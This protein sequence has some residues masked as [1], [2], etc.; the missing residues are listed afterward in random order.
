MNL[1][2]SEKLRAVVI[3]SIVVLVFVFGAMMATIHNAVS[4]DR[5]LQ[6]VYINGV[7][8]SGLNRAEANQLLDEYTAA[9][10]LN[11]VKI[12]AGK[13][14][15]VMEVGD[16]NLVIKTEK[17]VQEAYEIGRGKNPIKNLS[18]IMRS[19]NKKKR[20][21]IAIETSISKEDA[22]KLIDENEK[23]LI[24]KTKN[25]SL[26]RKNGK[27]VI[28]DEVYGVAIKKEESVE[29]IQ[30]KVITDWDQ[31]KFK[32]KLKVEKDKPDYLAKDMEE[33][34][35]VIGS[36]TTQYGTSAPGRK[37][38][39]ARGA[40]LINGTLLLPGETFS[41]YEKISPMNAENG[42]ALAP[43]YASGQVVQTY[44]GGIC[45]VSTTLYN[46]VLRA[47]LKVVERSNHSMTV[48]YVPLAADAAISGTSKDFK[49]KNDTKTPIY[50]E[51]HADGSTLSFKLYGKETRDSN[52]RLEF[53][54]KTTSVKPPKTKE[55][56][57]KTLP[58]GKSV[59][60][61]QGTTGYNAELYKVV[62]VDDK[63][64]ERILINRSSYNSSPKIVRIGAMKK[65]KK[66]KKDVTA[67][68]KN[69][70]VI[71]TA[72]AKPGAATTAKKPAAKTT[73]K[74]KTTTAK[75]KATT[76]KKKA[77]AKKKR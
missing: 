2:K 54:S 19:K 47:E 10:E 4:D 68:D 46:A 25:A 33:V 66:D 75:K 61:S 73:A 26:K 39:V 63:E 11:S 29:E 62:Y 8:V 24:A 27:F 1:L 15:V 70:N 58:I 64:T 3:S 31:D 20:T 76:A 36:Y 48:H 49:F 45:Q 52:R 14:K 13:K 74:K 32:I 53:E 21:D 55:I 5:I 35:D 56:K 18:S 16:M 6:N 40:S 30:K 41:A 7:D 22:Q 17:A 9:K 42:Y 23:D 12:V 71:T 67:T 72:T 69:G 43:S 60:A 51:A 38:N 59:V 34:K 65:D 44:G 28:I 37:K 50:I 77:T 57:D